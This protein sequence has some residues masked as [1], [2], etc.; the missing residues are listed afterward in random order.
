MHV[1]T[2]ALFKNMQAP[3]HLLEALYTV[4]DTTQRYSLSEGY[5]MKLVLSAA[6]FILFTCKFIF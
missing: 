3:E 6:S 4:F 1:L 5:S 2:N